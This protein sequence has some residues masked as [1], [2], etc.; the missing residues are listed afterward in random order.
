MGEIKV[1][2]VVIDT[3][4]IVSALLFGGKPGNLIPLWKRGR[5]Q[6]LVSK[7]IIDEYLQVLAYPKFGLTREEIDFILYK[8]ILPHFQV[9]M[10]KSRPVIVKDD[11]SDD[12]FIHCAM[13]GKADIIISGDRHLTALKSYGTIEIYTLNRFLEEL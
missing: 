1:K 12:K 6:P 4:V 5:I 7:E 9:V 8:E 2:R 13:A 11:P 3:N 10:V